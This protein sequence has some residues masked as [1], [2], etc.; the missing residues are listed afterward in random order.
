VDPLT[1]PLW[2]TLTGAHAWAAERLDAAARYHPDVAPFAALPDAPPPRAWP[3]L[4]QLVGPRGVALL[5][6]DRVEPPAGWHQLFGGTGVQMVG[7]E[8]AEV[9]PAGTAPTELVAADVPS[10]LDLV[11][12]TRP[13]PF[14]PR[15]IELGTYLGVWADGALVAM[16]GERMR[17]P[18]YTEISAVC[19]HPDHR[20]RGLARTLVLTLMRRMLERGDRPILHVAA[21]NAT[22][23][24]LYEH[25]GFV[26]T[27]R[28]TIVGLRAPAPG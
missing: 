7:P 8:R 13:G 20:G 24:R 23:L 16:A 19:T 17:L 9:E 27:R 26:R 5:F 25:L 22:A 12:R 6:R 18:G 15:T 4:A 3:A 28:M 10:M 11:E 2:A 1:N 14:G 21:D